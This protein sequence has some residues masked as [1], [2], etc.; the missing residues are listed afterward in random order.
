MEESSTMMWQF[1]AHHASF[2][3]I[4]VMERLITAPFSIQLSRRAPYK[5]LIM[6]LIMCKF[7]NIN[8]AAHAYGI[9]LKSINE[10]IYSIHLL[11]RDGST[12]D[13]HIFHESWCDSFLVSQSNFDKPFMVTTP[14]SSK[15]FDVAALMGFICSC[16]GVTFSFCSLY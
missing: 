14:N 12:D 8:N 11:F 9:L 2:S 13:W 6:L 3:H 7:E 4:Q 16:L 10:C 5:L 15:W 1:N